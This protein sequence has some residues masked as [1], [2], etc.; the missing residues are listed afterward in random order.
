MRRRAREDDIVEVLATDDPVWSL[1]AGDEPTPSA[2]G[3]D[4][5]RDA[6]HSPRRRA[7]MVV[8]GL[9]VV[10]AVAAAVVMSGPSSPRR[11]ATSTSTARAPA[12]S[13]GATPVS[14]PFDTVPLSEARHFVLHDDVLVPYSADVVAIPDDGRFFQLWG[15]GDPAL[16]W[17]SVAAQRGDVPS[18]GRSQSSRHVVDGVDVIDA[19]ASPTVA[20][21]VR[22]V[23]ADWWVTISARSVA[24]TD[25]VAFARGVT[26]VDGQLHDDSGVL[27]QLHLQRVVDART[28]DEVLYGDVQGE[29]QYLAPGGRTVTLRVAAA[30]GEAV[31]PDHLG[32]FTNN[33]VHSSDGRISAS[34]DATG[35]SLVTWFDHLQRFTLSGTLSTDQLDAFS[36]QIVGVSEADWRGR[37]YGLHPDFE[38]GAFTVN[39]SGTAADGSVW[40]AGVQ[41][42]HRA[43]RPVFL[44]WWTV[45]G[46][47]GRTASL[48]VPVDLTASSSNDT[49]VVQGAT[50]VFV[51]VP[52]TTQTVH[53][54]VHSE[55]GGDEVA[56]PLAQVR[57]ASVMVGVARIDAPG[58]VV[59]SFSA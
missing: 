34:V 24:D 53:V 52:G 59:F 35:E 56:V 18:A 25:L 40:Q 48:A 51:S 10:A 8:A 36:H 42:G 57:G 37:V 20:T 21:V 4:D 58:R 47:P 30:T 6:L 46:Q 11:A 22:Q 41:L 49:V 29:S 2:H 50:Y 19:A 16:P 9:A 44:W 33:I 55:S 13:A 23:S 5:L 38:L 1:A 17:L 39:G 32:Y 26:I 7:L 54:T 31:A 45:P 27:D 15:S 43:G 28:A 3:E 12:S 14:G